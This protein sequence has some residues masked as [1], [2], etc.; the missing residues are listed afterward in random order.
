[1]TFCAAACPPI[2]VDSG[3][4]AEAGIVRG[5]RREISEDFEKSEALFG[6]RNWLLEELLSIRQDY[7]VPDWDGYGAVAV[8]GAAVEL[9]ELFVRALSAELPMPEVSVE[10][11]G[12]VELGWF[13]TKTKQLSVSLGRSSRVA[14]AWIDGGDHGHGVAVF[15]GETIP[16]K[17]IEGIRDVTNKIGITRFRFN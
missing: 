13:V 1:M 4:S 14:Y 5:R 7:S 11:D 3:Y 17:I 8:S 16:K 15:D 9:A 2:Y 12:E 6:A 10:P